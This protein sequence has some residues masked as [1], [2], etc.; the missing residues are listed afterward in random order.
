MFLKYTALTVFFSFKN[1]FIDS[2]TAKTVKVIK[3]VFGGHGFKFQEGEFK[4]N[5]YF[6]DCL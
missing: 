1:K 4:K 3:K 6:P 2:S 5:N